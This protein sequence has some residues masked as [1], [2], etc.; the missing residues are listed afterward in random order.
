MN[1]EELDTLEKSLVPEPDKVADDT[2]GEPSDVTEDIVEA[3][4]KQ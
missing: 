1:D 4:N 2:P 3:I